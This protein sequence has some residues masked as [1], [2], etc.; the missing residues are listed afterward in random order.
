MNTL[1]TRTGVSLLAV[2]TLILCGWTLL[3]G[4]A[5]GLEYSGGPS[6][7]F[8]LLFS[9]A[10]M[11]RA[12]PDNFSIALRVY[13][14]ASGL[15]A[16]LALVLVLR[17]QRSQA[18]LH[19]GVALAGIA[20]F[21]AHIVLGRHWPVLA[22]GFLPV[23]FDYLSMVVLAYGLHA[24]VRVALC[25]PRPIDGEAFLAYSMKQ[26]STKS[27][28]SLMPTF[29]ALVPSFVGKSG[30]SPALLAERIG[31]AGIIRWHLDV[32]GSAWW[33]RAMALVGC[34]LVAV[35]QVVGLPS[36][37]SLKFFGFVILVALVAP[38][39]E[40]TTDVLSWQY[41]LG[42]LEQR[43]QLILG[44]AGI[45]GCGM[46]VGAGSMGAVLQGLGLSETHGMAIFTTLAPPLTAIAILLFLACSIFFFGAI[47][48]KL[49]IR[50]VS[51]YGIAATMLAVALAVL[52]GTAATQLV[53]RFG[54]PD[55]SGF[56]LAASFVGLVFAPLRKRIESS[57]ERVVERALPANALAEAHRET[58]TVAF[59]DMSG[60]TGISATD[61]TAALTLAS[62]LHKE[63]RRFAE[64]HGGRLVKTIGDAVLL[65]FPDPAEAV[66]AC[67]ELRSQFA[68][69][70]GALKLPA[71][72]LHFGL[73]HGEVVR[74]QDGDIFGGTVNLAA[75]LQGQAAAGEIVASA[76]V[77]A[78]LA[79]VDFPIESLGE[80]KLKNVPDPVA[81][82]RIS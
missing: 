45:V 76:S 37:V 56:V 43:K 77:V 44:M 24:M 52:Q 41:R 82:F 31:V 20:F 1:L 42:E 6:E 2:G 40:L 48:P 71:L 50:K 29:S 78:A 51:V 22:R 16:V 62:L 81:C 59:G 67:Q 49:A 79:P 3:Q 13:A 65:A 19:L 10:I 18:A 33:W 75:R 34:G 46:A 57:V 61:E 14:A 35:A 8:F 5:R 26:F 73:H 55:N 54:L 30:P 21:A 9:S 27:L 72:P 64:R 12:F 66:L 47:D 7:S 32:V 68:D 63:S 60:Y 58:V 4:A 69:A 39:F 11:H 38:M 74:D 80:R 36:P 15:A 28:R 17:P 25:Y 53:Q 70:T 23:A